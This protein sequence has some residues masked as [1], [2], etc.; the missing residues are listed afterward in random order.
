MTEKVEFTTI[1][2][3]MLLFYSFDSFRES[4]FEIK[5][6]QSL[7]WNIKAILEYIYI[8]ITIYGPLK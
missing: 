2:S 5:A 8:Y 7:I 6:R 1:F 3:P 4:D